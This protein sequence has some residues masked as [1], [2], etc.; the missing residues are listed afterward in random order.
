MFRVNIVITKCKTTKPPDIVFIVNRLI[1]ERFAFTIN[2][3]KVTVL[4]LNNPEVFRQQS[5]LLQVVSVLYI[6]IYCYHIHIS[7]Y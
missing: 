7:L 2:S 4:V 3:K 6:L 5:H 1:L